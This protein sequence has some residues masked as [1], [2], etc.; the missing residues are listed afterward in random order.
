MFVR[1][2][3]YRIRFQLIN[4][5]TIAASAAIG[6]ILLLKIIVFDW[7]QSQINDDKRHHRNSL[8]LVQSLNRLSL[9]RINLSI[10]DRTPSYIYHDSKAISWQNNLYLH[11]YRLHYCKIDKNM[12]SAMQAIFCYIDE[13]TRMA[14]FFWNQTWGP[15]LGSSRDCGISTSFGDLRQRFVAAAANIDFFQ[16]VCRF[17]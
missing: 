16:P 13:P 9:D 15:G 4:T 14:D 10:I 5:C 8:R 11:N 12:G 3:I 1:F 2:G 17:Y 7:R 6:V